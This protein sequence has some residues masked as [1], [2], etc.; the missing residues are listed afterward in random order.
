MRFGGFIDCEGGGG[1]VVTLLIDFRGV[2]L[3]QRSYQIS[4]GFVKKMCW[5]TY[6][7]STLLAPIALDGILLLFVSPDLEVL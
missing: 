4:I 7:E 3:G 2:V 6:H 1:G 5:G